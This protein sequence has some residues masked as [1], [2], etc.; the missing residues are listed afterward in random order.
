MPLPNTS[1][2]MSP[3]PT[4]VKSC[5]WVSHAQVAE[6]PLDRLPG[7]A[8]G[9]A[10]LL[11]V[12]AGRAAGGE[13]VA[14]PEAVPHRDLVG[15]V[16]ERGGALVGGHHQ[17]R[18]VAVVADHVAR[19][20][21]LAADEVVGDVEQRRDEQPVAGDALGGERLAVARRLLEHE[22]ALGADRH[23]H[24]VLH[25]L[26]LDQ[27]EDLG[28]EVL[29]PVR[30]AQAAPGHRAEPQ[31]HALEAGRVHE[32]LVLRAG[33]RQVRDR[34][35]VELERHVRLRPPVRRRAGR[36]W[37][38]GSPGSASG[39]SAG[40][41][42]GRGWPP[43]RA[44]RCSASTS[45]LALQLRGPRR[46]SCS[47]GSNRVSNSATSSAAMLRVGEK[48]RLHV[49]LGEDRAGLAQVLRVRPQHHHL[50]PGQ[51]GREHQLVEP[52]D[53]G[54]AAPGGRERVLHLRAHLGQ[55]AVRRPAAAGRSRTGRPCRRRG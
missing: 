9:D 40:S 21:D 32:D 16:G 49:L 25:H 43:R 33:R 44:A 8:G 28:A 55:L 15:D 19:R 2:D 39:T 45:S 48:R 6:V 1:P 51:P 34:L 30:P 53:L 14:E 26:R 7:A 42:P 18:V 46:P 36:S 47:R 54:L 41:G 23:D 12:V 3:T 31:V 50:P 27:A 5:V 24:R 4:T 13:R 35:R 37:C 20:H 52:V 29:P 17:V 22:A 11:V 38:A 10:H